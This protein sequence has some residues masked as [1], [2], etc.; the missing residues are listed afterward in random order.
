M[1]KLPKGIR[2]RGNKFYI[3][4]TVAGKRVTRTAASLEDALIKQAE[5]KKALIMGKPLKVASDCEAWTLQKAHEVAKNT[6]WKG[7]KAERSANLNAQRALDFFGK[8]TLL[9]DITGEWLDAF[10]EHLQKRGNSNG[11][12]NRKLAALSMLFTVAV[13]RGGAIKRPKLPRQKEGGGRIRWLEASEEETM[14][15]LLT[16]WG[17]EDM[18]DVVQVLVDTGLRVGELFALQER[19][20]RDGRIYV[21]E[22]KT[23]HP[24][25][26]PMTTRV[27][28]IVERRSVKEPIN[29]LFPYSPAWIRTK[30]TRLRTVMKLS[31]D[32][33][34]VPHM[35]R[36]T[37]ASR[38]VQRGATIPVVQ[39][40]MG[41]RCIQV[42]MRYAHLAPSNGVEAIQLLEVKKAK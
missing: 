41:H 38:L 24:R 27:K 30:W 2:F 6:R 26:I 40:L 20:I 34:F 7:T 13:D 10:V 29:K 4:V 5:L 9:N 16:Q 42:T 3:D 31:D 23:D 33:Q 36:H 21:W 22:N 39:Q 28:E 25:A 35:L 32:P 11:G 1:T 37:F 17:D 14:L 15:N 18:K 12:V 8:H 19:D